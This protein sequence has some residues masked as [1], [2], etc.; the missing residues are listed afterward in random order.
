MLLSPQHAGFRD[1]QG[2]LLIIS[3][4]IVDHTF[5]KDLTMV[6]HNILYRV[7]IFLT[8]DALD[9]CLETSPSLLIIKSLMEDMWHLEEVLEENRVL[10]TKPHNKTPYERL[11]GRSP[12]ID[13]MKPFGYLVTILNTLDHLGK[14]KRKADEGFFVG[15]YVNSKAFRVFNSRTRMVE[16]NLH[17]KFLKNKPNIV[18]RGPKWLF[19][20][21]SLTISMNLEPVTVRNQTNHNAGKEIHD[22]A[23]QAR[24]EKAYDHEYILLPFM[25]S[26]TQSLDDKDANKLPGRGEEGSEIDDQARTISSTQVVNTAGLSINTANTNVNTGSLNINTVGPNDQSM[27]SL[28]ETDIFDDV[29]ND[30][31]VEAMQE[32]FLQFKIQK[33]WTL[34]DIPNGKIAIGTKWVFRNK[35]DDRGIVIRNK[36]R[37][38]AQGYTQGEGIDYDEV[39]APIAKIE[40]IRLFLAYESFMRFIVY[41]MDVKSTFLYGTIEEEVYVCQPLGFEDPHFPNKVYKVEKALY[42]LHQA[43]RAWYET[44]STYLLENGF[45]R[46]TIGKTL[47]IKMDRDDA[48]EIPN[49]FYEGTHFLLRVVVKTSSTPIETHKALLKDKEAQDIFRYLKGQAKL[50]LWYPRDSPFNLEAF[51]DSDF[52]GASLNRKSTTRDLT[53]WLLALDY[54]ISKGVFAMV[55]TVNDDVRMQALVDGKNVVVN[56]ASIRC[57]LRLNDAEGTACLLNAAIFEELARMGY[58]KPSQKLTFYKAFFSPQWKFL[59]HTIMQCLSAKTTVWNEFS[60]TMT[61][62]IICL[63]NNKKFKFSKY[64]LKNMVRNLEAEVKFIMFPRFI[65]VFV[66]HQLGDMSHHKGIFVNPSLTRKTFA[67]I[68]RVGTG[69][70]REI[71]PL[72]ATMMVQA[73]EEVREIPTDAQD[74]PTLT[75]P[76]S[77][78]AQRKHKPRRKQR[79]E[80]K[81]HQE[82]PPTEEHILT[83]SYDPLPSAKIEKLKKIVKK[84]EGKK[85]KRTHRLKRLYKGRSIANIDQDE[86]NT[87]V[88]DTHGK[89]NK[90][91]LFR[92]HDLSGD[93]V[94]MDVTTGE[95]IEQDATVAK[96]EISTADP[97]TTDGEVVTAAEDVKVAAAT[98]PQISKDELTLTQTLMEIKAAKPKAKEVTIQE[99]SEFRTTSSLQ[100]SQPLQAKDKGKGIMVEPEKPLKMKD[101]IALDE[102]VAR[103]LEAEMKAEMEEEDRIAREKEEANIAMIAE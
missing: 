22:N 78:Q 94:F 93:E 3:S 38:V 103:K 72:F 24:Q 4:K 28:E 87:L 19:D 26:S 41:Q 71:T 70:S 80:T 82:E 58:E 62:I 18:G 95:N 37:L 21:D 30:R 97:V 39:F 54:L 66:N 59:I 32:E 81:V 68:K 75:Q 51:S 52:A 86:G 13:F 1:Q 67:N 16:E 50:G 31:E 7:K 83:P 14:F 8:L 96:K 33:V 15:Y 29:Y 20:I 99:P 35:K 101:Q 56:E 44:M 45:R 48:Q 36:A 90:E 47:F 102:E 69:F 40:A 49:E 89:M 23:G 64:I 85:K 91:D 88:N 79:E 46:E 100:P 57:D 2:M 61:S 12:N 42:S 6:I 17:I 63:A 25:P 65:Q 10:V 55:K 43:L 77:S 53:F 73:P 76:S 74:T 9:V 84:L 92:V 27:P 5:L 98:I 60:S 11:L 34:V